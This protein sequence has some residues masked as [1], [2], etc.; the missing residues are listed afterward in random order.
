MAVLGARLGD[1]LHRLAAI[2]DPVGILD[3]E[4]ATYPLQVSLPRLVAPLLVR[5]EDSQR[6]LLLQHVERVLVVAG[7]DQDL[8]EVLVQALGQRAVDGAIQ[9]YHAAERGQRVAR[10]RLRVGL[11]DAVAHGHPARVVVLDDHAGGLLE[12]VE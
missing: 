9:R 1:D 7:G 12:V 11:I 3:Q 2:V 10:E 4:P 5:R 8:D 6:L